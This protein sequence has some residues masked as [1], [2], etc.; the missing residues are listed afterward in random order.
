MNLDKLWAE[1]ES[2]LEWRINEIRFFQNQAGS[3][4]EDKQD[5]FRRA[6]ILLLYAHFEGF[7]K[8]A[9]TLYIESI[10]GESIKCSEVNYSLAAAALSDFFSALRNPN[11]KSEIFKNRLPDDSKLHM[12]AREK[13]FVENISDFEMNV[14]K[15]PDDFIDTESNL[16][17]VV[18]RKILFRLGFPHDQFSDIEGMIDKLLNFRNNIAH[19]QMKEGIDEKSYLSIRD[20]TF[21]IMKQIES[22]IMDA[23]SN[24]SYLRV[25]AI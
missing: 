7:S 19:G 1:I 4:N 18:L 6:I 23:L 13:E 25:N 8:F 22:N 2:D 24:Q 17:P 15:I 11:S 3:I 9:F 10:N 14:V 5:Q 20:S 16:K 21:H 12:F